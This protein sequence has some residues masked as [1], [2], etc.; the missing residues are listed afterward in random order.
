MDPIGRLN[1]IV[2]IDEMIITKRKYKRGILVP[3]QWVVGRICRRIKKFFIVSV[4]NRKE[5][6]LLNV[7][8]RHVM[9]G[10]LILTDGWREYQNMGS[11]PYHSLTIINS[12]FSGSVKFNDSHVEHRESLAC[13]KKVLKKRNQ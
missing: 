5:V 6:T 7:I 1:D 4:C 12:Q 10:T 9:P 13:A 3:L 8:R 11:H 2:E